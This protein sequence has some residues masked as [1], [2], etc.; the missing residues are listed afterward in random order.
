MKIHFTAQEILSLHNLL[1][2]E[3]GGAAC[4]K[5]LNTND[6]RCALRDVYDS[7]HEI[8][9]SSLEPKKEK[10]HIQIPIDAKKY[11]DHELHKIDSLGKRLDEIRNSQHSKSAF[12][13]LGLD[14]DDAQAADANDY[15]APDYPRKIRRRHPQSP[16]Q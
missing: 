7:L 4:D 15:E 16:K 5:L 10:E 8:I 13:R 6:P 12:L 2:E 14:E 9:L 11:F 3:F 1:Y